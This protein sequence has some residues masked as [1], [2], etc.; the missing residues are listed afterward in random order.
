MERKHGHKLEDI[1][2]AYWRVASS[3]RIPTAP[4][5]TV[6]QALET[7]HAADFLRPTDWR[8]AELMHTIKYDIIQG[9]NSWRSEEKRMVGSIS[10]LHT[11]N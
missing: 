3:Y 7:I 5:Q 9:D 11:K 6:R 4:A 1:T 10:I 2:Q 8:L